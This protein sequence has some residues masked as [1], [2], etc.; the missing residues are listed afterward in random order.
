MKCSIVRCQ[1]L[2]SV[3]SLLVWPAASDSLAAP[4]VQVGQ[5]FTGSTSGVNSD[6]TPPDTEG[7]AG[8]RYFVELINGRFSV[9]EKS[10]ATRVQT[11]TDLQFWQAAGITFGST[12]AIT[13]PRILFDSDSQ[14]WFAC[15]V[16]FNSTSRKM[17]GNR[18]LLAVSASADPTGPWSGFAF[19]A[20]PVNLDFAD[21]P[22]LGIDAAAVYLSGDMFDRQNNE[23][24]PSLVVIPKS[25]LVAATPSIAN[26]TSLGIHSVVTRGEVLQP[27]VTTGTA[28]SPEFMLAVNDA[29]TAVQPLPRLV[30]STFLN[31]NP[32]NA[33]LANQVRISVPAYNAPADPSQPDGSNNLD[34]GDLRFSA[35]VRRVGDVVYAVHNVE[36]NGRAA[37]RWYRIHASD[38]TLIESGTISDPTLDLFYPSIAA[39]ESGIVVIGCSGSSPTVFISSY[40]AVG[41]TVN[42]ALAFGDLMLLAAGSD[43]YQNTDATGISRWG[44]YSATTVDPEDSNRFW[45]IQSIAV[46]RGS[47]ATQIT[48]LITGAVRLTV[49]PAGANLVVS[50]PAAATAYQLQFSPTLSPSSSWAPVSQNPTVSNGVAS[51]AL[52]TSSAA[53]FFRLTIPPAQ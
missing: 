29:T 10:T 15:M 36:V 12:L 3:L 7:A 2:L 6:A 46:R 50:W 23:V 13:D 9:Y 34:V 22:T 38:S 18:F 24:G 40:A 14:R 11:K 20:D 35:A 49:V 30:A 33:T 32:T 51:I 41:E 4:F 44:D 42:G 37:I 1:V 47:W 48:E 39:N 45:T 17:S 19:R 52:P 25:D 31:P 8:P 5:N 16:D 53:G 27:A 43:N 26:R 21:F 28:S